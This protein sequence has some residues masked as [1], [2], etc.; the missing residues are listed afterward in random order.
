MK[1]TLLL[2]FFALI[3]SQSPFFEFRD[4]LK[5]TPDFLRGRGLGPLGIIT[6]ACM[7]LIMEFVN[8]SYWVNKNCNP[9]CLV[10]EN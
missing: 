8:P 6:R 3:A 7:L 9:H 1:S 2:F 5:K 4:I 10:V